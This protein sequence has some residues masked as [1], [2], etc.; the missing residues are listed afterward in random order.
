[1]HLDHEHPHEHHDHP[2]DHTS[3]EELIALMKYMVAHNEAHA[4]E[5]A[6]LADRLDAAG[7]HSAYHKVMDAVASFDTGNAT[8]SAVLDML[9]KEPI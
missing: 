1:M 5:L 9:D 8:L 4:Q 2:H 7:N 3:M 6:E